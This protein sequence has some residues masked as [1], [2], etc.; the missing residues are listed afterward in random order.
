MATPPKRTA[1]PKPPSLPSTPTAAHAGGV[2]AGHLDALSRFD[3]LLRDAAA[4]GTLVQLML[5]GYQGGVA[6]I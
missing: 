2:A 3:A 4:R 6:D 5:V 1:M